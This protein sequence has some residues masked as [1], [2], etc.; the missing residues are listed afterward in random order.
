MGY[1]RHR[2]H[3]RAF[4]YIY[5][6]DH[7]VVSNYAAVAYM[8]TKDNTVKADKDI[9]TNGARAMYNLAMRSEARG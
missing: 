3:V 7:G 8:A 6:F 1:G 5:S 2:W 4:W 9:I